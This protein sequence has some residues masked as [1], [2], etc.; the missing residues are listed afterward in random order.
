MMEFG[1]ALVL[2][3]ACC[4]IGILGLKVAKNYFR[5]EEHRIK[6]TLNVEHMNKINE[7]T[8][9]LHTVQNSHRQAVSTNA[10]LRQNYE[11]GYGDVEIDEDQSD[12]FKLSDLA[13]AVYPKLPPSLTK[14]L[15]KEE[16]HNAILKTVEKKPDL[17]NTFIEKFI[18][19]PKE[20]ATPPQQ[21]LQSEY[22]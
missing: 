8:T 22:L 19:K 6:E 3:L 21:V 15:D 11:L 16:F 7:L 10:A 4:F 12:E 18:P 5:T 1:T 20:D 9:K 17:L 2:A 14:I 13:T